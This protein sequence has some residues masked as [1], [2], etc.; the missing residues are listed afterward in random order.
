M[1]RLLHL[2]DIHLGASFSCFDDIAGRRQRQLLEAFRR[3]PEIAEEEDV[4]AVAIAGD[5]FDGP[6]PDGDIR[7][8][9]TDTL[10][11]FTQA[12]RPVFIV[13]G[14][15]DT[16][17]LDSHPEPSMLG[18]ARVLAS[19]AFGSP[20][21]VHTAEGL[22]HVYG[23][24]YDRDREAAPLTT[25]ER[26]DEPGV[27]LVILHGSV[28]DAL[29][30]TDPAHSLRLPREALA[31]FA[32]DYIALG[33]DHRFRPPVELGPNNRIPACY[34]GAFVALD[35]SETGRHGYVIADLE[36]GKPPPGLAVYLRR[37]GGP[38]GR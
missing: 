20:I 18:G 27:H 29:H 11:R 24:A 36:A 3:L 30:W 28:E 35:P 16:A 15:H 1:L 14:G 5:L 4:D 38:G 31:G 7:L 37:Y 17:T 2:A 34:A 12:G 19:G 9:V 6:Q 8:A 10:E 32:A 26:A 22:L 13:P 21:S 25:F 33:G 23:L